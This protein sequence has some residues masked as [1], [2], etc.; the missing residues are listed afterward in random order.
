MEGHCGVME[1]ALARGGGRTVFSANGACVQTGTKLEPHLTPHTKL[2][3][4]NCRSKGKGT[5]I[6][7]SENNVSKSF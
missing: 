3:Q 4:M 6:K 5:T 1:V 2:N 7:L